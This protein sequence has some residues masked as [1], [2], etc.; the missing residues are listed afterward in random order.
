MF[1]T[2]K[3]PEPDPIVAPCPAQ[4]TRFVWG[5]MWLDRVPGMIRLSRIGEPRCDGCGRV[6]TLTVALKE[7]RAEARDATAPA[8]RAKR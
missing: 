7:R 8:K 5:E 4:C 2:K 1:W 6:A 3:K